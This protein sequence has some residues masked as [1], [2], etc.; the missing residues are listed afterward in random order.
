MCWMLFFCVPAQTG[1]F[2]HIREEEQ[3]Q[4]LAAM[5]RA[6]YCE[7]ATRPD[8]HA[9]LDE[10]LRCTEFARYWV[11]HNVNGGDQPPRPLILDH[12]VYGHMRF[13]FRVLDVQ[14]SA[15]AQCYF[16]TN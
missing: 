10:L 7:H 16:Y 6:T 2:E 15:R 8:Y 4:D 12:P 14:S 3:V 9:L 11:E 5:F 13:A 1:Y